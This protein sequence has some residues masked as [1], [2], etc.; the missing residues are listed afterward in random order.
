LQKKLDDLQSKTSAK[1]QSIAGQIITKTKYNKDF[2]EKV[3]KKCWLFVSITGDVYY[4]DLDS[5]PKNLTVP[6][7]YLLA[8]FADNQLVNIQ[9]LETERKEI[10]GT[11][12]KDDSNA[13]LICDDGEY[14][15]YLDVTEK[16]INRPARGVWLPELDNR[17][18]GVYKLDILPDTAKL[19]KNQPKSSKKASEKPNKKEE[20]IKFN[21]QKIIIFGGDRVGLEYE[22]ALSNVNL[23]ATWFS[24]FSLL[25]EISLGTGKPD[26][27]IVVTKQISHALL[28]ELNAYAEKKSIPIAYSTRRGITSV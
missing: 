15:I 8:T 24:G 6:E 28:R 16:W 2:G 10:L 25:S 1:T 23:S 19:N 26:L 27:M 14:P 20:N 18:A 13:T 5:V 7:E 4:L 9:S 11:I 3:G 17:N 12:K 22:K 21:G